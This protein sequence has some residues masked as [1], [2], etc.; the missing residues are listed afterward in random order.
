MYWQLPM[1]LVQVL[2]VTVFVLEPEEPEEKQQQQQHGQ[3][4]VLSRLCQALVAQS[5]C[6]MKYGV[7]CTGSSNAIL[8]LWRPSV[9][10]GC[11]VPWPSATLSLHCYAFRYYVVLLIMSFVAVSWVPDCRAVS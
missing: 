10:A 7:I 8:S 1:H 11:A 4:Q 9:A 5:L 3:E 2:A 6:C